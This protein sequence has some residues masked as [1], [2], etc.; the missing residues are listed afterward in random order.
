MNR[1]IV[2]TGAKKGIWLVM[3]QSLLEMGD[4]VAALDLSLENRDRTSP[5]L[6][7]FRC[8]VTPPQ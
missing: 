7:P 6:L 1:V 4:R 5:S 8:H 3:T 2:V